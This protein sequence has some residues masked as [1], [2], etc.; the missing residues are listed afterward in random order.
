MGHRSGRG[1]VGGSAVHPQ[2]GPLHGRRHHR[3]PIF[4]SDLHHSTPTARWP[5]FAATVAE[6]TPV[7]VLFA[8]PLQWGTVNL[9]VLDLYR[10][11]PG[12]LDDTA[13]RDALAA[14]DT[15]ALMMLSQRTEPDDPTG[16]IQDRSGRELGGRVEV[17]QATGMVLA[18]LGVSA[19][20]ALARM[21]AHAFTKQ[22]L[23]I[24]VARDVVDRRLRF[25]PEQE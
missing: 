2:R 24:D 19:T 10:I 7:A 23:L 14:V 5:I 15:A 13:R 25:T 6:Q 8:L 11:T 4:I 17:A 16:A 1:V 3:C 18:Q 12:G 9:G 21:R 22:R 20:D